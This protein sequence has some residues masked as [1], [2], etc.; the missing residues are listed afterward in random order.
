MLHR[1]RD[2]DGLTFVVFHSYLS[3]SCSSLPRSLPN[4]RLTLISIAALCAGTS[5]AGPILRRADNP[6]QMFPQY[7]KGL[8]IVNKGGSGNGN[9]NAREITNNQ[10][11]SVDQTPAFQGSNYDTIPIT[12]N[13]ASTGDGYNGDV[14]SL[15]MPTFKMDSLITSNRDGPNPFPRPPY[16]ATEDSKNGDINQG[17]RESPCPHVLPFSP[18]LLS[19]R[20][21][22][23]RSVSRQ[24]RWK[25]SEEVWCAGDIAVIRYS[26]SH[27]YRVFRLRVEGM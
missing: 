15:N 12:D 9:T 4:M 8:P 26:T 1:S 5:L 14:A 25:A 17:N 19:S 23:S 7:L 13:Q 11:A 24:R 21:L 6:N 22:T 27:G 3:L 16:P 18:T 2:S 20:D 10:I